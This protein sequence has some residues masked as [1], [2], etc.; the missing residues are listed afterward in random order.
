MDRSNGSLDTLLHIG[1][2]FMWAQKEEVGRSCAPGSHREWAKGEGREMGPVM[3]IRI[4]VSDRLSLLSI[5]LSIYYLL[6]SVYTH[7]ICLLLKY[8]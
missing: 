6:K 3:Y 8:P 1:H 7:K 2:L 4:N 5:Y